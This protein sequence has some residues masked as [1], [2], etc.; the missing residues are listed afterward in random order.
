MLQWPGGNEGGEA[1][2]PAPVPPYNRRVRI[3]VQILDHPDELALATQE[4]TARGWSV[5]P[6]TP[7]DGVPAEERR[8]PYLVEVRLRGAWLGARA[9]AVRQV[10]ALAR[11]RKLPLW[12]RDS[13]LVEP[14]PEPPRTQYHARRRPP[15]GAGRVRHWAFEVAAATGMADTQR[16]LALPGDPG[17]AAAIAEL[18][19]RDLG[20]TPFDPATHTVRRAVGPAVDPTRAEGE[21]RR[22]VRQGL[23]AVGFLAP[24]LMCGALVADL[25]GWWRAL[26]V[27]PLLAL[28]HPVGRWVTG[29]EPRPRVVRLAAG[30]LITGGSAFLGFL[31]A[32]NNDGS[33]A[34]QAAMVAVSLVALLVLAG[35]WL[36]LR[37]SWLSRNAQWVVPLLA[38]PLVFVLPVFGRVLHSVYL[39]DE[40]GIPSS[41]VPIEFY[42]PVLIALPSIGLAT[43]FV[44]MFIAL[45]GWARHLHQVPTLREQLFVT[46]PL[47][48]VVYVLTAVLFGVQEAGSAARAAAEAAADGREPADYYGIDGRLMCVTPLAAPDDIPILGGPLPPPERPVL[49]FGDDGDH[50]WLWD[51]DRREP[52]RVRQ[53]DVALAECRA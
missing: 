43:V 37:H 40:F 2:E 1:N 12:I 29:N 14:P 3:V 5:R 8:A 34:R 46:L 11:E 33:L 18:N 53:E 17:A 25:P 16:T 21:R 44:L 47:A 38:T 27:L 31:W 15:P 26:P 9:S 50:L 49:F 22:M 19:S 52:L 35:D 20:G 51:P 48:G 41:A 30:T 6:A 42:W 45:G 36:A 23:F 28:C 32:A 13:S 10:E 24:V 4:L 7:G 39:T